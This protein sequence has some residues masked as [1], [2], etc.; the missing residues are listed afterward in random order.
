[1]RCIAGKISA[2]DRGP[3]QELHSWLAR[4]LP[5]IGRCELCRAVTTSSA[6]VSVR[7]VSIGRLARRQGLGTAAVI[8]EDC[9]VGAF[10]QE[11]GWRRL[12]P[13]GSTTQQ[14]RSL[15]RLQELVDRG[16]DVDADASKS[17]HTRASRSTAT[18]TSLSIA[19]TPESSSLRSLAPQSES[20]Q[21]FAFAAMSR[22]WAKGEIKACPS[23]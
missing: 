19:L 8:A 6:G 18:L 9:N 15:R 1:M 20:R 2:R 5:L 12:R 10:R 16:A 4:S 7:A 14:R 13:S 17:I 22:L 3:C 21:R 11:H 23:Q